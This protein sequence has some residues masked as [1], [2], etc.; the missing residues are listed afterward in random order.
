MRIQV[1]SL[2]RSRYAAGVALKGRVALATGAGSERGLGNAMARALANA[3][4]T[5]VLSDIAVDGERRYASAICD[6]A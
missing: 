3:G 5:V 2:A 6:S 4:A 1:M